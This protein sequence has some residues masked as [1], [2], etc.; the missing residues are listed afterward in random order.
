MVYFYPDS[1]SI[2]SPGFTDAIK[3]I[4]RAGRKYGLKPSVTQKLTSHFLTA[5]G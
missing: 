5:V 2:L 1:W 4:Q 3:R